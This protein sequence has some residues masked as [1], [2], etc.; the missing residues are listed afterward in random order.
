MNVINFELPGYPG[1]W[2]AAQQSSIAE[3]GIGGTIFLLKFNGELHGPG[4]NSRPRV[5]ED[6][7]DK[8]MRMPWEGARASLYSDKSP[9]PKIT[10]GDVLYLWAHEDK[11]YGS[12]LGLTGIAKAKKVT[13]ESGF[14]QIQLGDLALLRNPFGFRSLGKKGWES[15]ILERI[16]EDRRPKA[17]VM[18]ADERAELDSVIVGYGSK[19]AEALASAQDKYSSSLDRALNQNREA[20]LNAEN[21]RR[22]TIVKARPEQQ[23]FREEAMRRHAGRCVVTGFDVKEVLEAAHVI[24]HTGNPEFEVPE[25]SLILR[26]DVHALFDLGMIGINEKSGILM[27]SSNLR[28]TPYGKLDGNPINHKLSEA[29]L[30]YQFNRFKKLS[31]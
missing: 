24:P 4:G 11:E 6:W 28:H 30:R 27:V 1:L 2:K 13:E 19:K 22:T 29:S 12:G 15:T 16:N 21:E 31:S 10:V 14:L 9:G 3:G 7:N 25:N 23:K 8:V 20:V 18:T 5:P 17:W 26:R